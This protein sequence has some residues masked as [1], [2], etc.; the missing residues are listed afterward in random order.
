M[1]FSEFPY[2]KPDITEV[3]TYLKKLFHDFVNSKSFE[4]QHKVFL[5]F[6]DSINDFFTMYDIAAVRF[7][8]D[9][10]N[11]QYEEDNDYFDNIG[12]SVRVLEHEFYVL[13]NE[14]PFLEKYVEKYGRCITRSIQNELLVFSAAIEN[15]KREE[16]SLESDYHILKSRGTVQF[17]GKEMN[18]GQVTKFQSSIDRETRKK[19]YDVV[20]ELNESIKDKATQIFQNLVQVRTRAAKKSGF[21]N[22]LGLGYENMRKEFTPSLA[23]NFRSHVLKYFVPLS[24]KLHERQRIRLGLDKLKYYDAQIKFKSGNPIPMGNPDWIVEQGIKMF[25]E[26]S[27]LTKEFINF[28][29]DSELLD[30]YTRKGKTSGGYST[31]F[32]KYKAPFIFANMNG[33]AT[34]VVVFTHEAGHAFQ[35]YLCKDYEIGEEKNS[36]SDLDEIHSISM[37]LLTFDYM[38]LFFGNDTDKFRYNHY[39]NSVSSI[40]NNASGDEFQEKVYLN[41]DIS[42]K[43]INNLWLEVREKYAPGIDKSES[44]YL[45]EGNDWQSKALFFT[46]PLYHIEYSLAELV[47]Y[48]FYF[49]SKINF[50]QTFNEYIEFCKLGGKYTFSESLKIAGL[51]NPFEEETVKEIAEKIEEMINEIDDLKF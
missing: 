7:S 2:Y 43:E 19:A 40:V 1:K 15:E 36:T 10:T 29:V 8:T 30:L 24:I 23:G 35:S 9:T 25:S 11:K 27:P 49:R 47:A 22:F 33:T 13:L 44:K 14:S 6:N 48:Q 32:V 42:G 4:E 5:T 26:I 12:P 31:T 34:D 37:E 21:N 50:A 16:S 39:S 3:S 38:N 20:F 46:H 28:M 18:V 17:D 51:K 45:M 41:P